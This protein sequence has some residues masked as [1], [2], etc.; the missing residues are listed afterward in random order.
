MICLCAISNV[1]NHQTHAPCLQESYSSDEVVSKTAFAQLVASP[2]PR[3]GKLSWLFDSGSGKDLLS[4][5]VMDAAGANN[6]RKAP[7]GISLITA[8]GSTEASKIAGVKMKQ[9]LEPCTPYLLDECPA[10]LS[11]GFKCLIRVTALRGRQMVLPYWFDRMKILSNFAVTVMS[12]PSILCKVFGKGQFKKGKPLKKLLAVLGAIS[13]SSDK[14]E[15][16]G[17]DAVPDDDGWRPFGQARV[18]TKQF[19][20]DFT[21][22]AGGR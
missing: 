5:D 14:K 15:D 6:P 20:E 11:V 9:L 1:S 4:R 10:V 8:I 12:Q 22:P 13:S 19:G 2:A 18:P 7:Q 21:S 16:E 3:D 17:I